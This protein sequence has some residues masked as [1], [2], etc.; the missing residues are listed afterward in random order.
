MKIG[1][2]TTI[3]FMAIGSQAHPELT[4]LLGN[5]VGHIEMITT[6]IEHAPYCER[7]YDAGILATGGCPGVF[8]YEVAEPF[9]RWFIEVSTLLNESVTLPS[10]EKC[11]A[12]LYTLALNFFS[13]G[14]ES[15]SLKRA[16]AESLAAVA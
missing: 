3:A 15:D 12:Q 14:I 9:G 10:E 4:D 7:L 6:L 1:L 13:R 5:D 2:A 16:L 11:L 8:D